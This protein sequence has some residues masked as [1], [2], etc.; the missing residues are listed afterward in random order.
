[1]TYGLLKANIT[2]SRLRNVVV[3]EAA[4]TEKNGYSYLHWFPS[5]STSDLLLVSLGSLTLPLS[6]RT[7][8]LDSSMKDFS[9]LLHIGRLK[10][11]I[12]GCE[13]RLDGACG[14]KVYLLLVGVLAPEPTTCHTYLT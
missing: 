11:N 3:I 14:M 5:W 8:V 12:E 1:M 9:D 4:L 7:T 13:E 10:I 6:V 2:V